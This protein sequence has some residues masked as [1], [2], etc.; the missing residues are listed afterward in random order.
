MCG[1]MH[2]HA[3]VK[4]KCIMNIKNTVQKGAVKCK[5][6]ANL[7]VVKSTN[8][9]NEWWA[10]WLQSDVG[11]LCT[12]GYQTREIL[13]LCFKGFFFLPVLCSRKCSCDTR[14]Y[15]TGLSWRYGNFAKKS[16]EVTSYESWNRLKRSQGVSMDLNT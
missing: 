13:S 5:L 10:I 12:I 4:S 3:L 6:I 15:N 1:W 11:I 2:R 14:F 8:Q 7:C 9:G 16:M